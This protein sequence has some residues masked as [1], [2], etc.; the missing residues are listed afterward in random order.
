[1]KLPLGGGRGD[2]KKKNEN[3]KESRHYVPCCTIILSKRKKIDR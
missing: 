2:K 1:M 3:E